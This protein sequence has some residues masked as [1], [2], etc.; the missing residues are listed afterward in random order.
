MST[1]SKLEV[2]SQVTA[3][4]TR[5]AGA[6]LRA[7]T[8]L[9]TGLTSLQVVTHDCSVELQGGLG[10]LQQAARLLQQTWARLQEPHHWSQ[11]D[12]G[13][14]QEKEGEVDL[15]L[16]ERSI[17]QFANITEI[18]DIQAKQLGFDREQRLDS[19]SKYYELMN[20]NKLQCDLCSFTTKRTSH[21]EK[22]TE[23]HKQNPIIFSCPE[24]DCSFRC[25][26]NG[27][28]TRHRLHSHPDPAKILECGKCNYRT[29]DVKC[30]SRHERYGH[31][32]KPR[33]GR[34]RLYQ[35]SQC[36]YKTL[37][38]LFFVRHMK[39]HG[40][41]VES[42]P[43]KDKEES[44]T[45]VQVNLKCEFCPY[46][47]RRVEHIRRHY[48]TVHSEDRN[49]L[50]QI[51]GIG[52][53]RKDALTQH[54]NSH[55][56]YPDDQQTSIKFKCDRCEKICRSKFALTEHIQIHENQKTF[57]CEYCKKKFN[58]ANILLKHTKSIHSAPGAYSCEI[59]SK[60]F[61]T[62]FN[63][64]RHCKTHMT[65]EDNTDVNTFILEEERLPPNNSLQNPHDEGR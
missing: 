25:I 2:Y 26:R 60:R 5:Q 39:K 55:T 48:Q 18:S 59:C 51:C 43:N 21:L 44:T 12:T 58:T 53:K 17:E 29:A 49:F 63:L 42:N 33:P 22:H 50:C 8:G 9:L 10:E 57:S 20:N 1:G 38:L 6:L 7:E 15:Q 31:R 16:L 41:A 14:H 28:L 65:K 45:V 40:V 13:P 11:R 52:F 3:R 27:D 54:S 64:K 23:M 32:A 37:K 35:C 47:A 30:F 36:E 46:H 56:C 24:V 19:K 61:N 4:L 34:T 62:P